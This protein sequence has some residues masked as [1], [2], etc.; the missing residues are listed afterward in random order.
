MNFT[1]IEFYTDSYL[2][3]R[4]AVLDTAT[5]PFYATKATQTIKHY[6][7]D[8]I[9]LNEPIND[10]VQM[11]TCELAEFLYTDEEQ[12][13]NQ[14]TGVTSEKVGEFSISYES[15]KV[16]ADNKNSKIREIIYNWLSHTG[17]LYRGL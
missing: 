10:V 12:S 8:N 2:M 6:T 11:C 15:S 7:F 5:F 14:T 16:K 3:G 9:S 17:Y 13:K 1:T 4:V